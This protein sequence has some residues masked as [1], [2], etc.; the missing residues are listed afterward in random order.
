[1]GRYLFSVLK[2]ASHVRG[3]HPSDFASFSLALFSLS[4]STTLAKAC[5]FSGHRTWCEARSEDKKCASENEANHDA[6]TY[7]RSP[8]DAA[9]ERPI[10]N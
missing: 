2:I 5:V 8:F 9:P 10:L 4:S 6:R 3:K 1:M 7:V